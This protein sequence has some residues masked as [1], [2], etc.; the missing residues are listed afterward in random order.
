MCRMTLLA[1]TAAGLTMLSATGASA[2]LNP[3]HFGHA[4]AP[5]QP[6]NGQ[7]PANGRPVPARNGAATAQPPADPAPEHATAQQR[8]EA[9]RLDP[10]A[11]AAFWAHEVEVDPREAEAGVRLSHA[12]RDLGRFEEA[13]ATADRVLVVNPSN[14]DAMLE[15]GRA[16]IGQ[17][18]GFY[19]I[20]PLQR[21]AAQAPNDWRPVALLAVAYEQVQRD[22]EALAA[23]HRAMTMAP[24]NPGV[25]VNLALYW[26]GHGD[27]AQA[28]QLLRRAVAMP[29][30]TAQARQNLA[31]ILGLEGRIDEAERLAR[32]DLPPEVVTNNVEYLRAAGAPSG[33]RSW[34]SVRA[35]QSP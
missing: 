7:P 3:F 30:A 8:T 2:Q 16:R 11:R 5:A 10:L 31:L 20:E 29:G 27:T 9:E 28:E 22:D 17:G 19:A 35:P 26:A 32:Q 33:G 12:L 6:S 34:D 14:L 23:Y 21:A 24:G 18:Q 13:A 15:A 1:A 25:V 4:P